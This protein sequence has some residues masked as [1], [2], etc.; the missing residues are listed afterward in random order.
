MTFTRS[1][2]AYVVQQICLHMHDPQE[3]HLTDMKRIMRY[4]QGTSD[5]SL[6]CRLSCSDLVVY[7][8]AD[9]DGCPDI[10]RSTSGYA[11]ILGD[12]LVSWLAKR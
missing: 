11:V 2:I 9:W 8:D 10:C 1:D 5:Y 12:N 4:L 6:M 3:P 7:T